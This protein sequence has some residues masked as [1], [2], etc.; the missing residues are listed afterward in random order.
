MT[1]VVDTLQQRTNQILEGG[2]SKAIAKH[3]AK[4]KLIARDRINLLLDKNTAFLELSQFSGYG[5]Y[6][7][8]VINAA[9]IITGIGKIYG[10]YLSNL[11]SFK[12]LQRLHLQKRLYD[13][14]QRCDS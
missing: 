13:C 8:D 6:G 11:L 3:T 1:S 2:G 4:G 10:Y 9:G 5:M 7:K 12:F 14:G